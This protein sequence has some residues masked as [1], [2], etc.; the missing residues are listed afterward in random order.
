MFPV[1]LL[2]DNEQQ[3]ATYQQIIENTIMINEY[4]MTLVCATANPAALLRTVEN[5]QKGLFFLDMEIGV[6]CQAGLELAL[7]IRQRIPFAQIVFVTTHEELAFLTLERKIAPLDYILKDQALSQIKQQMIDDILL[8]EKQ[9]EAAAYHEKD[10]FSYKIGP[11][12]FSLP[13]A[14]IIC[15]YTTKDNPGHVNLLATNRQVDFLGNLNALAE[16]YPM[17]FRCDKS[18]LVNLTNVADYD[19][20]SRQLEFVDGSQTKVS[21]RK[22]RELVLRLKQYQ[23]KG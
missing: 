11:R 8:A 18:Y 20:K 21:F 5:Q 7:T 19:S 1:Y 14:E 9:N 2:E 12:F 17:F 15:L 6:N 16:R 10:L 22:S 4:A 3:Q 23:S 13:L